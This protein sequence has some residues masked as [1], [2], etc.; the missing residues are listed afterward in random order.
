[1]KT[2]KIKF[3]L[4][5]HIIYEPL[6]EEIKTESGLLLSGKDTET[7]NYSKGRVIVSPVDAIRGENGNKVINVGDEILF[8][9]ASSF[10]LWLAEELFAAIP[11]SAVIGVL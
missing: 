5:H 10:K 9:K 1:M 11:E 6:E 3:S 8:Y 4:N 2:D 7:L